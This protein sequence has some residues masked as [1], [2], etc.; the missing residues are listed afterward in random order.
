M[1]KPFEVVFYGEPV[2]SSLQTLTLLAL[3]FDRVHFPGVYIGGG[4]DPEAAIAEAQRIMELGKSDVD[5]AQIVNSILYAANLNHVSDFCHFPGKYGYPGLIEEGTE[6]LVEEMDLRIFGPPPEGFTPHH[7][8][9]FAKGL[10]GASE[11]GVNAPSWIAYPASALLYA[12]K[13]GLLLVND[14]PHLP[15]P[16]IGSA[17]VKS[18]ATV[19][20]TVLALESV[21]F[22]LP[23][24]QPLSFEE[25]AE[26][27]T[28]T[29]EFV[30]PFRRGM[31]R[32]SR[33]LNA[34]LLS[35]ASIEDVQKEAKFLVETAVMPQL[36]ELREEL[37]KPTW[38]W[39][40]RLVDFGRAAPELIGN[41]ATLPT[42]LASAKLLAQLA[43]VLA[44]V[45]DVE[46][47]RE[48]ASRRTGLHYL[49]K[50]QDHVRP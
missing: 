31:V 25:I 46:L 23:S 30:R 39:H 20:S 17:S 49:L 35:D 9:G 5:T 26:L 1:D 16:S 14:N 34:A 32:L 43:N 42:A 18:Q 7:H 21:R 11:A 50:L 22:T 44:D 10:E 28:E 29:R 47:E 6:E 2:P 38:P 4:A 36:E 40:R 3:V 33:D 19:L 8:L 41:F 45:R 37:V 12:V 15:I 13:N 48:G 24:F 27:R